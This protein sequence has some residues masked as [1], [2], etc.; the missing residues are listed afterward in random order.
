M[1]TFAVSAMLVVSDTRRAVTGCGA[2]AAHTGIAA[3]SANPTIAASLNAR[4]AI[5]RKS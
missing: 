3:G 1:K 5:R 2:S 4:R